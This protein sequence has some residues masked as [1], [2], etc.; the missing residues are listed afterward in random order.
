MFSSAVVP[1]KPT[2]KSCQFVSQPV[3]D[4]GWASYLADFS[5][6]FFTRHDDDILVNVEGTGKSGRFM[7]V[8][9]CVVVFQPAA[10]CPSRW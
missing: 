1:W 5:A 7:D 3:F 10:A 6:L 9:L 2:A 8:I 4:I